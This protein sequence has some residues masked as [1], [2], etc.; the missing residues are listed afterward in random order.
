MPNLTLPNLEASIVADGLGSAESPRAVCSL[1]DQSFFAQAIVLGADW[2][3]V[4]KDQQNPKTDMMI[5]GSIPCY[6]II[7]C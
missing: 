6:I 3:Q 7:F 2:T 4:Q 1:R 5:L